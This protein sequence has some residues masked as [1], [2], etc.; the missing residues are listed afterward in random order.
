MFK[1]KENIK[2]SI[3]LTEKNKGILESIKT[4]RGVSYGNIVNTVIDTFVNISVEVKK[5]L[6][7][8]VKIK[9]KEIYKEMDSSGEYRYQELE[10]QMENYKKIATFL[11]DGENISWERL[12]FEPTLASYPLKDGILICP[13]NW[14]MLNRDQAST[15]MYAGVV[16]CRNSKSF[17]KEH[18]GEE[19]PH[20]VY[21]SDY[22]YGKDYP[23]KYT[24][25]INKLCAKVWP[26]FETV[27]NNQVEPIYN[28]ELPMR[29]LNANEWEEAP[30]IGH[31][32]IY[33]QGDSLF[34]K[35]Y[36]PLAGARII[37]NSKI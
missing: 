16:E 6:L 30:T 14:I 8:I 36:E 26:N 34:G 2:L 22:K 7:A 33:E 35:N 13:D 15:M 10:E 19:I 9:I 28:P 29:L 32:S 3:D 12:K 20:F 24:D 31:F 4:E 18:F 17:G 1:N 21:F 5:E 23:E 25:D 37:R 27:I 11:N